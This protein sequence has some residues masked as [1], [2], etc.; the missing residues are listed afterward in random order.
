M[1]RKITNSTPILILFLLAMLAACTPDL[2]GGEPIT[3]EPEPTP[4]VDDPEPETPAQDP[5]DLS[6]VYLDDLAIFVSGSQIGATLY[7]HGP[8]GCFIFNEV[9]TR[10]TE[11]G[12]ELGVD[13]A[14]VGDVCTMALVPFEGDVVFSNETLPAGHYTV[15]AA[16]KS[17]DFTVDATGLVTSVTSEPTF[18][19]V[20]ITLER[21]PCFGF[22]PTYAV[23]VREDGTV[24]YN[25][26]AN[27][28]VEGEQ[29][30]QVDPEI[31]KQLVSAFVALD[32]FSLN[33]TYTDRYV[34]DMPSTLTSI[35]MDGVYKGIDRYGGDA[36]APEALQELEIMIDT[37]LN[38]EQWTGSAPP[39][40]MVVGGPPPFLEGVEKVIYVGPEQVD[41][42]GV[43]PQKCLLVKENL[44]DDYSYFY[45]Q[46]MDFDYEPG[47]EYELLI[48]EIPVENP[49]ADG[50]S[51]SYQ[52]LE[53]ISKVAVE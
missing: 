22:C 41:C 5:F 52:L 15:T 10:E 29:I 47:F 4:T 40:V 2:V 9:I 33:D 38:T 3:N 13:Y 14:T 51:L 18:N 27:V 12:W 34:T 28:D 46:I 1:F 37:L 25:G 20:V 11:N 6:G 48:L 44:A 32:Y 30:G 17:I 19:E 16:D 24:T 7:G 36:A 53:L 45:D 35:T 21:T 8:N 50:S 42:E 26:I 23:E 49:P 39:E 31:V 43:A